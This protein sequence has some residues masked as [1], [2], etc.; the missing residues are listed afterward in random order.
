MDYKADWSYQ[1]LGEERIENLRRCP[2]YNE[3]V[4]TL[5]E[6]IDPKSVKFQI[7]LGYLFPIDGALRPL[8]LVAIDSGLADWFF[9]GLCGYRSQYFHSPD[10]GLKANS[11]LFAK[12]ERI[13]L[14][15][16]E[17]NNFQFEHKNYGLLRMEY[18]TLLTSLRLTSA[19]LWGDEH[20]GELQKLV[21]KD[22]EF[23]PQ[24]LAQRWVDH[25]KAGVQKA[26]KGIRAPRIRTI[27]FHGA[28]LKFGEER[29]PPGK[30]H[31]SED[32]HFYGFS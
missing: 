20:E 9:N 13:L 22:Q 2:S 4:E 5:V 21:R 14:Q 31:R 25:A 26:L 1:W 6:K 32:I 27:K 12:V 28:F 30:E 17:E 16:S 7:D 23:E 19:K 18:D 3:L 10:T 15:I 24:I 29:I 8:F 11:F